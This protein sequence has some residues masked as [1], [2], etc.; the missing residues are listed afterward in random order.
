MAMLMFIY[1]MLKTTKNMKNC[2]LNC[3]SP[4]IQS[5]DIKTK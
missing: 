5:S 2:S 4:E 3:F 1:S